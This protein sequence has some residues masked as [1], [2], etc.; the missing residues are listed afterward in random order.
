[1]RNLR[2]GIFAPTS[3][4]VHTD[5]E[6]SPL[7]GAERIA[8]N[9]SETLVTA[10]HTCK[11]IFDP[12]YEAALKTLATE[13]FDIL[14]ISRLYFN[15][16]Y[17][18]NLNTTKI[19]LWIHDLPKDLSHLS[20]MSQSTLA[21]IF[22]NYDHIV[23]V[24]ES[25]RRLFLRSCKDIQ[26][27]I[28]NSIVAHHFLKRI[29]NG[30]EKN[31][32]EDV[33]HCAHPQKALHTTLRCFEALHALSP[34][35]KC[36]IV[37]S[38]EIYQDQVFFYQDMQ[39]TL[40]EAIVDFFGEIPSWITILPAL[41]VVEHRARLKNYK[42]YLHPDQSFET[43][44]ITCLEALE[45]GAIPVV[46]DVGCLPELVCDAGLIVSSKGADTPIRFAKC[47]LFILHNPKVYSA[48]RL[49]SIERYSEHFSNGE[50][51]KWN[52]LIEG[53]APP[54]PTFEHYPFQSVDNILRDPNENLEISSIFE[55]LGISCAIKKLNNWF[56]GF[57]EPVCVLR[58]ITDPE[59]EEL[60]RKLHTLSHS[61]KIT[62][63]FVI[64]PT[65]AK[66]FSLVKL[67]SVFNGLPSSLSTSLAYLSNLTSIQNL[68]I[69]PRTMSAIRKC[70]KHLRI[71]KVSTIDELEIFRN[72]YY[73]DSNQ[74]NYS[75]IKKINLSTI[76][77]NNGIRL[78]P[79]IIYDTQIDSPC[80]FSLL[81][82]NDKLCHLHMWWT[83]RNTKN[84]HKYLIF[85]SIEIAKQE[86]YEIIDIGGDMRHLS[87]WDGLS[88]LYASYA[89][90][91][92]TYINLAIGANTQGTDTIGYKPI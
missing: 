78:H 80:G 23:F 5:N 83:D 28:R 20:E 72:L 64:P 86:G 60:L 73:K 54:S 77:S 42:I 41:P 58:D 1:M 91:T 90:S 65:V 87:M 9:L 76:H 10:G 68:S 27:K 30:F 32:T 52:G 37:N 88:S 48:F 8:I 74:R 82:G 21:E 11:L 35:T 26:S 12:N 49:K 61:G 70:S 31:A 56:I 38:A 89:N 53:L 40:P 84:A 43:G 71:S 79:I 22:I 46:S 85:N 29:E 24:S 47:I 51:E 36:A 13:Q 14:I 18:N 15:T 81:L 25:Q 33:I 7:A 62:A 50:I 63:R 34:N 16:Q 39:V 17:L 67:M 59:A 69:Q 55:T 45:A 92:G 2:V 6:S 19:L 44:A 75:A 57:L 3:L 66:T 4:I